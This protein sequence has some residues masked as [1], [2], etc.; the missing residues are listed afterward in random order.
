MGSLSHPWMIVAGLALLVLGFFMKR[1]ASRHDLKDLA[2]DAAWQVAKA[3]GDLTAA[4]S[5]DIGQRFKELAD[6]QSNVGRAKKVAGHAVRH[7]VAQV[8]GIA[9][10]TAMLVGVILIGLAFYWR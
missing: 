8:L 2:V 6:E 7:V 4:Q 1:W 5:S 9:G 3:K 10:M